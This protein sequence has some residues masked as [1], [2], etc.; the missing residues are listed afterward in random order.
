[1]VCNV[2]LKWRNIVFAENPEGPLFPLYKNGG[3]HEDTAPQFNRV[4]NTCKKIGL[5]FIPP[6]RLRS[7]RVNWLL[8]RSRDPDLTAE[9]DQHHKQ[10]LLRIYEDPSMQVT[11][12]EI[13]RF[14]QTADPSFACPAPGVCDGVPV[15]VIDIPP[16]APKPDCI[17]PAGCLWCDHHRDIDSEDYVW[18]MASMRHLHTIALRGF[19]SHPKKGDIN[20]PE[21]HIELTIERLSGKLRY[22]EKSNELRR[23]WVGESLARIDEASYHPHWHY[24]IVSIEGE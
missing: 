8:R 5:S 12:T 14:W 2:A 17:R 20:N 11:M 4:R 13:T 3:R 21:G 7:T 16:Q 23:G 24:I 18:S 10:T 19:I 1:M 22:F 6:S 15:P 9:M